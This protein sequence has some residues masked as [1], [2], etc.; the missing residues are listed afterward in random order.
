MHYLRH[1]ALGLVL[2]LLLGCQDAQTLTRPA[3]AAVA[4]SPSDL[5]APSPAQDLRVDL[6]VY[7][8]AGKGQVAE[9][10]PLTGGRFT[11]TR[12]WQTPEALHYLPGHPN[13]G[14]QCVW[15]CSDDPL[16]PSGDTWFV[17]PDASSKYVAVG[18]TL[19]W[20]DE[21]NRP[22]PA[23]VTV[24]EVLD[25]PRLRALNGKAAGSVEAMQRAIEDAAG[26]PVSFVPVPVAFM[27]IFPTENLVQGNAVALTP[28]LANFQPANGKLYF[29]ATVGP[30]GSAGQ[31]VFSEE[32]RRLGG[33]RRRM[34]PSS[35]AGRSALRDQR[36]AR[37]IRL[38]L[39]AAVASG[40][41]A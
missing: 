18:N 19:F 36:A 34:E 29:P 5:P 26:V 3:P 40:M 12:V 38:R 21:R 39:V 28:N 14:E 8:G 22:V 20:R 37:C 33:I 35:T 24:G 27:G 30:M 23:V 10:A 1:V 41:N 17:T 25:D 32:T 31:D 6:D 11:V 4:G 9:I 2:V 16:V 15:E 13:G 7:S